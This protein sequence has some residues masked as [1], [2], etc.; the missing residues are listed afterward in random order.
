MSRSVGAG[1]RGRV[2]LSSQLGG[3][4]SLDAGAAGQDGG[5]GVG[6]DLWSYG[7]HGFRRLECVARSGEGVAP[8]PVFDLEALLQP[9]YHLPFVVGVGGRGP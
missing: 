3:A 9:W 2:R 8:C 1:H 7:R 5:L 6:Y 4:G